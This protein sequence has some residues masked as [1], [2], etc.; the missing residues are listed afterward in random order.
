LLE[1][2]RR[3]FLL[4]LLEVLGLGKALVDR[5]F[6]VLFLDQQ[7]FERGEGLLL[8]ALVLHDVLLF[9][10]HPQVGVADRALDLDQ[11]LHAPDSNTRTGKIQ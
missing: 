10:V 1:E 9:R 5:L 6:L 11:L 7:L 3:L 8:A 2:F 4:G